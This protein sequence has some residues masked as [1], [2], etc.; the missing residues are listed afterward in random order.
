MIPTF[1]FVRGSGSAAHGWSATQREMASRGHRTLALD[2]PGRGAD[3]DSW[4]RI[5]HTFVKLTKD[6]S[7]PL[8][9][10]DLYIAEADALTP[11]NPFDVHELESSHAGFFRKPAGL[12]GILDDLSVRAGAGSQ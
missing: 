5:S 8:A 3:K 11:D 4:G 7:M 10:Q 1:V 9:L 12:A 6:H 2:L